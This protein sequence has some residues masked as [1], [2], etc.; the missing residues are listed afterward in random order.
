MA[1]GMNMGVLTLLG[2]I[3]S[4]LIAIAVF[5]AYILR[6]AARLAREQGVAQP[7]LDGAL[8]ETASHPTP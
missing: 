6:R 8:P 5:F 3:M 7:Q 1:H 2:V 4:V